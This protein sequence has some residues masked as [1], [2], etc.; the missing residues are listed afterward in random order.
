MEKSDDGIYI[1]RVLNGDPAAYRPLVERY[2]D[3]AY[4]ISL[5]IV[6]RPED[7]ED[8]TQEAFVKAYRSLKGFKREA[9]FSTWLYR[10]V[11]NMSISFLRRSKKKVLAENEDFVKMSISSYSEETDKENMELKIEAL[12]R[13][14]D[15]LPD[16]EQAI[17]TL[18]YYDNFNIDDIASVMNLTASNVKVKLHRSRKKLC[19]IIQGMRSDILQS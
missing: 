13:A 3:M 1:D 9:R 12:K 18:Y 4:N 17:I 11:Y 5:K 8:I 16:D 10:I 2:K 19:G 15:M 14:T 6:K 7:A